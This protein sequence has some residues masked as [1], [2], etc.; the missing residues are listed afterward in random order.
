MRM[1]PSVL[2]NGRLSWPKPGPPAAHPERT[3][4]A[5]IDARYD[6]MQTPSFTSPTEPLSAVLRAQQPRAFD[7][8]FQL[9]L[10]HL[11]RQVLHAAIGRQDHIL[12]LHVLERTLRTLDYLLRRLD[13]HVRQIDHPDHDSFVLQ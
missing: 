10:G 9:A 8:R 2:V 7:E 4:A 6:F 11:A 13:R 5:M 1:P 12:R 3:T